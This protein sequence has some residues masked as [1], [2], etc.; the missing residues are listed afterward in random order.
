[1]EKARTMVTTRTFL[2]C[3][4]RKLGVAVYWINGPT[5]VA[6]SNVTLYELGFKGYAHI[7]GF[8]RMKLEVRGFRCLFLGTAENGKGYRV[9]DLEA[10]KAKVARLVKL[11]ER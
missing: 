6:P 7:D 9:Y 1:M 2:L 3:G 10:S 4:G 8:R 5:N 11:D